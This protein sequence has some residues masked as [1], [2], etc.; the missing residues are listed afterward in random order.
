MRT[1]TMA[2]LI[3]H[4][5]AV[6]VVA[7]AR[8]QTL[9]MRD[10]VAAALREHP[11]LAVAS[12]S[13]VR[14]EAVL[15]EARSAL[16]PTAV[17]EG[18]ATRFEEPMVVAPL[19]GFDPRFPPVFDRTLLQASLGVSYVAFDG[20]SRSARIGR[21]SSQLDAAQSAA[22]SAQ[23]SLIAEIAGQYAA[24]LTARDLEAA[25][26]ARVEALERERDRAQRLLD[27][28]RAARVVVLRADAALSSA[29][30]ELASAAA[31]REGAERAL[32]RGMGVDVVGVR[33][34][35]LP[36]VRA[37]AGGET[38]QE[39]LTRATSDNPDVRRL[40]AMAAAARRSVREASGQ[41]WPRVSLGGRYVR[42]ASGAGDA[43]GEWQTGVQLHYPLFTGG[44]R[45]AVEQRA[46]AELA[47][48]EAE[49]AL[50]RLRLAAA[51]DQAWTTLESA[52]SRVEAWRAA[53]AQGEEVVRIERLALD[54]GAG[55]QTD[56]LAAEADLLRARAALTQAR[57]AELVARVELARVTGDLT[58][59]WIERNVES[60][61]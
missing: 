37:G 24:V 34:A 27:E 16:L 58:V 2:L 18:T 1:A 29:R 59:Q 30:A 10:A 43:G 54:T 8:G 12:G 9:T 13:E 52:E 55:L 45:P 38:R 6:V 61:T 26:R 48:A 19:H 49:L 21:A 36:S 15:S 31:E 25:Q 11:S 32:A 53:V 51:V 47:V 44:A 7:P 20:G 3:V 22:T 5:G 28:G 39:I 33:N 56:Y 41:W 60:E 57:G 17:V 4:A 50:G 40:E 42:Y 14:A 35:A 46:R 23:Q